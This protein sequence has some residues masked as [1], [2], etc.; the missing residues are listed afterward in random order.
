MKR[1]IAIIIGVLL[2]IPFYI[3]ATEIHDLTDKSSSVNTSGEFPCDATGS[4]A[5]TS[6][7]CTFS[8]VLALKTSVSGNAGTATALAAN[9]SNCSSGYAA[10]GVDASGASEGCWQVTP[11][12]IGAI[13]TGGDAGT[14]GGHAAN[15]FQ[16]ALTY[17]VTG[18]ASPTA[19]YLTKWGASGNT[20]ADAFKFGTLTDA[21]WCIFS[22][23]NGLE[24]TQTPSYP[25]QASLNIDDIQTALGIADGAQ[26]FGT[27]TG[28][29]IPDNQTAKAAMQALETA[30]ELK[31]NSSALAT[32]NSTASHGV[33]KDSGG[34]IANLVTAIDAHAGSTTITLTPGIC[35]AIHNASQAAA[36]VNNT[37]P[38]LAEGLCFMA[39]VRTTR[40]NY[41]RLTAASGGTVCLDKTCSKNYVSFD[42]GQLAV[43]NS[44][45]CVASGTDHW[46]CY[47][48]V[49]T[50]VTN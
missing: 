41:W 33:Y 42:S 20:L 10:L 11:A 44:Y 50:A 39:Q 18:I 24:C 38:A 49:G 5:S 12:A 7:K 9:G 43:D 26:H 1:I 8:S 16:T 15:Y 36:D 25:T 48:G 21:K 37:L 2:I 32:D 27:F 28:S 6:G 40:T 34:A 45:T 14:L 19:A 22:T 29:T 30:V 31:A 3:G 17:P 23:A 46:A 35:P 13:A 4:G 47:S